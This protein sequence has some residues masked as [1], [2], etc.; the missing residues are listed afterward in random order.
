MD[1][2]EKAMLSESGTGFAQM[3][4]NSRQVLQDMVAEAQSLEAD[5]E[6]LELQLKEKKTALLDLTDI[7]IPALMQEFGQTMVRLANGVTVDVVD[8]IQASISKDKA[9]DAFAWLRK[10]EYGDLIKNQ[11]ITT[12]G[13]GEDEQAVATRKRLEELGHGIVEQKES[14]HAS[15]LKSFVTKYILEPI[16]GAPPLPREP[17]GV[18]EGKRAKIKMPKK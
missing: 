6:L 4:H 18:F 16:E 14:V 8:N 5:T 3:G 2:L 11:V 9:D 13:A 12:F 1:D 17:F 7:K 10:N 15:T